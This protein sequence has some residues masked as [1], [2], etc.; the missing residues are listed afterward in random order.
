MINDKA[1]YETTT[2]LEAAFLRARGVL[3]VETRWPTP[4]Q[5]VFVFHPPPDGLLSAWQ[6]GED[7]VSTRALQS[8]FDFLR[9]ELRRRGD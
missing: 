1:T 4:Q 8:A 6:R 7:Q 5:A 9:D 2:F 3:Y